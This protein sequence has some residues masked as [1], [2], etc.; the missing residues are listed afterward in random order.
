MLWPLIIISIGIEIIYY[1]NKNDIEIKYDFWGII[2]TGIVVFFGILFSLFNYG[3]N[4][5]LYNEDVK[6]MFKHLMKII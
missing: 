4:K 5:V 1:S 6:N 2:L 3:V